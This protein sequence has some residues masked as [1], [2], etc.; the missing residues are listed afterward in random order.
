MSTVCTRACE[1]GSFLLFCGAQG[2]Y[3]VHGLYGLI[4]FMSWISPDLQ[5]VWNCKSLFPRKSR[6]SSLKI[7]VGKKCFCFGLFFF[8][9]CSEVPSFKGY[10]PPGSISKRDTHKQPDGEQIWK[11]SFL[12]FS[13]T[14]PTTAINCISRVQILL[15][16]REIVSLYVVLVGEATS[17]DTI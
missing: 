9:F 7:A 4:I 12:F 17:S 2:Y 11:G 1:M 8:F 10:A 14:N 15:Y 16:P 13:S 3:H 6:A 5:S